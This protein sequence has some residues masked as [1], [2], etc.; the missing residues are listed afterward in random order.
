MVP[1]G[2][3]GGGRKRRHELA[4][5]TIVQVARAVES[6]AD[7]RQAIGIG[8]QTAGK[9][10]DHLVGLVADAY[11]PRRDHDVVGVIRVRDRVIER[12]VAVPIA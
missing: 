1:H 6:L 8:G 12:A 4:V 3:A 5:G 2:N 11:P 7:D 9:A 10:D